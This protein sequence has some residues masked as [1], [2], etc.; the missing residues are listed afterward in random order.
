MSSKSFVKL[1]RKVIR[2]EV[3]SAVKEIL[4]DNPELF[5]E[6]ENKITDQLNN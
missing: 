1:L 2:E 6:L 4:A 5:E 3:R